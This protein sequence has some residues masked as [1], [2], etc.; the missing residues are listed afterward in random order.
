MFV[1]PDSREPFGIGPLDAWASGIPVVVPNASGVL[2]YANSR[3]A[4]L[5]EPSGQAFADVVRPALASPDPARLL[6][7]R[8]TVRAFAWEEMASRCLALYERLH[9][10]RLAPVG[11][12]AQPPEC[13]APR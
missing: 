8:A 11:V 1:H 13:A 5:A 7:G 9:R 3:N 2:S 10:L 12:T 4:R 6:A